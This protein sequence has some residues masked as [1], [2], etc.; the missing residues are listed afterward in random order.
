MLIPT[1][2]VFLYA[3]IAALSVASVAA[4]SAA[5]SASPVA[6]RDVRVNFE[7][8]G[9]VT[10]LTP[11]TGSP[12]SVTI[13]PRNPDVPTENVLLSATTTYYQAGGVVGV[14]A[15]T[16]GEPVQM[17]VSG[18]PA[19]AVVVHIES[20]QPVFLSGTVTA[21]SPSTGAATSLTLQPRDKK[22]PTVTVVLSSATLYYLGGK[23]TTA[24]TLDVGSAVV[25]EAT[26]TP[27]T[28][29]VVEIAVPKPT[30]VDG[31]VTALT[32][33]AG[34]PTSMTIMPDGAHALAVTVELSSST[35][36]KQRNDFVTSADVLVGSKVQALASGNPVTATIVL[37]VVPR[38]I[39]ID[40]TVTALAP[41][42]GTPTSMTVQPS[43]SFRSPVTIGLTP[44]T[45]YSQ[46]KSSANLAAL[47]VGSRVNVAASGNP[48]S[49]TAVH[50]A[51]PPA[52]VTLGSVTAVATGTITVQ[53]TTVGAA[54]VTFTL[55]N[56]TSFFAGRASATIAQVNV[57]DIVRVAANSSAPSTAVDVTVR[58]IA[59]IGRVTSV[60][61]GVISVTGLYG[62][63][64]TVDASTSTVFKMAGQTSSL[65]SA[66]PG[67]FIVAQGPA[68]SGVTTSV[69]AANVW[70]GAKDNLIYRFALLQHRFWSERH[71]R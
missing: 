11:S 25:L 15:L 21:M 67:E 10:V 42:T 40:G 43:G 48:L 44:S 69:S 9:T 27:A 16:V 70:I 8:S 45:L 31:T 36:F 56:A 46:L 53:P 29:T 64:L 65:S 30:H 24:A 28:A 26:G 13:Q 3:A 68:I 6:R 20:P 55:T 7:V 62:A 18:S 71:H 33:T 17:T 49:A 47:L 58:M 12:T 22:K 59:I 54:P 5:A 57:G 37:I 14:S 1:Q 19:T 41:A 61:G 51:T 23:S 39:D 2:K 60:V 35:V 50:I 4:T 32:T 38:P 63:P 66:V 52:D 34:T